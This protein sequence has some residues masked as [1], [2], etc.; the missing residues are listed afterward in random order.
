[1]INRW[2]VLSALKQYL[3]PDE[4]DE[5]RLPALCAAACRELEPRI[6]EDADCD[7]IRLINAAAAIVGCKLALARINSD[8]G[9][10]SFKAGDVTVSKTPQA[11]ME[12]ALDEKRR[13][14]AEALPLLRDEQF[15]FMQV[16]A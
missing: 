5:A 1:M 11:V 7:D 2:S 3:A 4:A 16:E 6:K 8:N 14:F 12:I 15:L 10:T 9:L 13:A